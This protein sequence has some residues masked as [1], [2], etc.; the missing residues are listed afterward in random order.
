MRKVYLFVVFFLLSFTAFSQGMV[1]SEHLAFREVQIDGDVEPFVSQLRQKGFSQIESKK[2]L[3]FLR[4]RFAGFDE[5]L[6]CVVCSDGCVWKV[7]VELP[8]QDTWTSIKREYEVFKK[9]Y[10][11]K[12]EQEPVSTEFFPNYIPEGSGREANAFKDETAIWQSIFH[13]E[14]GTIVLSVQPVLSGKGRMYLRMEYVDEFNSF[15][16][17]SLILNDI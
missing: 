9:S 1:S 13:V 16:H 7:V 14:N 8:G 2:D 11:L 3:V 17:D 15:M 6:V 4:G 5:S 12:Y 10:T